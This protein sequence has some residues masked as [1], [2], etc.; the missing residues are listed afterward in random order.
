MINKEAKM[1]RIAI[2][3]AGAIGSVLGALLNR[4]GHE[5]TL[6]GRPNHVETIHNKGLKIEGLLGT[7]TAHVAA[8]ERLYFRPDLALLA[9]KTQ[10]VVSA[11]Q[12]NLDFLTDVPLLTLQNGIQSD[13]LVASLIPSQQVISVVVMLNASYLV[14]GEVTLAYSGGLVIGRPFGVR[15]AQV[16]QVAQILNQAVPTRVSNNMLGAHWLKL[17]VNLNN[18]LPALTNHS[19]SQVYADPYLSNLAIRLMREGMH[20]TKQAG[21]QLESLPDVSVALARLV[22]LLPVSIA[23]NIIA[24]KARRMEKKW[25]LLSSTLQSILRNSP[26][27]I[28]YLNGEIVRIGDQFGIPT[29]LNAKIVGL[30]HQVERTRKFFSADDVR[31]ELSHSHIHVK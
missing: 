18:A 3:G 1:I 13:E 16:E 6:I 12:S 8:S 24:V 19:M 20:V 10:D 2:I 7:F 26:T 28:D 17:I 29:P 27:E 4:A 21:I 11:L 14:P 15:D 31:Q 9:V 23:A 5:V 25:P 30:V 22:T